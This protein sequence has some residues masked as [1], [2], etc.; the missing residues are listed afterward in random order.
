MRQIHGLS[1]VPVLPNAVSW[2]IKTRLVHTCSKI[3]MRK[4][5]ASMSRYRQLFL[6]GIATLFL[7]GL[8]LSCSYLFLFQL[9]EHGW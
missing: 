9:A 3:L 6:T 2:C 5:I 7:S 8:F 1:A 4:L